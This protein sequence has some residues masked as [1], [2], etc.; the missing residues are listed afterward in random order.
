MVATYR[1]RANEIPQNLFETIRD[2]YK[3]KEVEITIQ[4]VEDETTFLLKSQANCEHLLRGVEEIRSGT[5][6]QSMTLEQL[7]ELA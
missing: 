2:N 6:L 7:N 1:L 3:D 5:A 4:E